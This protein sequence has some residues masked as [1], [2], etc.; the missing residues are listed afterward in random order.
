MCG[1]WVLI[2]IRVYSCVVSSRRRHTMCALVTGVQTCALPIF[3]RGGPAGAMRRTCS[4]ADIDAPLRDLYP[5]PFAPSLS[6]GRSFLLNAERKNSPSTSSGRTGKAGWSL[7]A[8]DLA[9]RKGEQ[10][11]IGFENLAIDL[12]VVDPD[13]GP[14]LHLG[15][16]GRDRHRIEFGQLAE[17]AAV[18]GQ[19][20][21]GRA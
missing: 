17:Q 15:E 10:M 3:A 1:R 12:V 16:H 2:S 21:I 11:A 18:G 8:R 6:K 9:H 20:K 4:R 14:A 19:R 13:A 7:F 5:S